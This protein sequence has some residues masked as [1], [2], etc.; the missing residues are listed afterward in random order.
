MLSKLCIIYSDAITKQ[1]KRLFAKAF[2]IYISAEFRH[3][4]LA[5]QFQSAIESVRFPLPHPELLRNTSLIC[6]PRDKLTISLNFRYPPFF[7]LIRFRTLL[8]FMFSALI[9]T[10]ETCISISFSKLGETRRRKFPLSS[11]QICFCSKWLDKE[12]T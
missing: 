11:P 5:L 6:F 7:L 10:G 8:L 2:L 9:L 3:D 4:S 12:S 1:F